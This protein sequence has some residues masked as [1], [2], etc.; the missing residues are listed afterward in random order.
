[1]KI[2]LVSRE[3]P[4][5]FGGG[6]G[7]FARATACALTDAGH[8]V[9]VITQAWG[10]NA[11]STE[12]MHGFIVHRL[13]IP[14]ADDVWAHRLLLFSSRVG[15]LLS[16]LHASGEIDVAEFPETE[17]PSAALTA[18]RLLGAPTVPTVVSLHT[19][20]ALLMS[21]DSLETANDSSARAL[22]TSERLAVTGAD[23]LC[24]PST[25]FAAW[26]RDFYGLK[27]MP[28]VIRNPLPSP[29]EQITPIHSRSMTYLGRLEPRKGVVE[30]AAAW[31]QA[32][33]EAAGWTLRMIGRDT[34]TGPGDRSM[35][36]FLQ[37]RDCGSIEFID[38]LASTQ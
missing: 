17:A 1:M 28:T 25:S 29:I 31:K 32:G 9:H 16:R 8:T 12:Q 35:R 30:L 23:R 24:A 4:P 22:F 37:S 2:A 14:E 3:F 21:L 34:R 20:S 11:D 36:S 27:S 13:H 33:L 7:T 6:I 5:F 38:A 18:A 26:V 19:C 10:G 15:R